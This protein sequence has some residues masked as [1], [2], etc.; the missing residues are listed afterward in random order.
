MKMRKLLKLLLQ[1]LLNLAPSLLILYGAAAIPYGIAMINLP[2]GIIAG[3]I[4]AIN[5]G[6]VLIK[7][8]KEQ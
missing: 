6:Y 5:V 2:A 8:S 4:M 3:G 7:G 1:L